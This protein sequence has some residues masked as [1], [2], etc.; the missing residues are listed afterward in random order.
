MQAKQELQKNLLFFWIHVLITQLGVMSVVLVLRTTT[1]LACLSTY[2]SIFVLLI[3]WCHCLFL[4]VYLHIFVVRC[5]FCIVLIVPDLL[6]VIF[7]TYYEFA[8][9][10]W[11]KLMVN[12]IHMNVMSFVC[13]LIYWIMCN[14]SIYICLCLYSAVLSLILFLFIFSMHLIARHKGKWKAKW[15]TKFLYHSESVSI[16]WLKKT[17]IPRL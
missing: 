14:C 7:R 11:L 6:Y 8:P 15:S 1:Y 17:S 12:W 2:V 13:R 10:S 9:E 16:A 3:L 4:Y 5:M